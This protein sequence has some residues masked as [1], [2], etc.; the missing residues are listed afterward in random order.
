MQPQ[1]RQLADVTAGRLPHPNVFEVLDTTG[2][3]SSLIAVLE[4]D[5]SVDSHYLAQDHD[6]KGA[7]AQA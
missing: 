2:C 5:S 3:L 4:N 6:K 1:Q 7:F